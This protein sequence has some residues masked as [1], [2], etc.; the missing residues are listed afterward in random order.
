[1]YGAV[2]AHTQSQAVSAHRVGEAIELH[3]PRFDGSHGAP[4]AGLAKADGFLE[5]SEPGPVNGSA[6]GLG[7]GAADFGQRGDARAETF[8]QPSV[9]R[10]GGCFAGGALF[11]NSANPLR[12][13]DALPPDAAAEGAELQMAVRI[14]QPRHEEGV[15]QILDWPARRNLSAHAGD[16]T[17]FNQDGSVLDGG[18][19]NG[20]NH[21]ARRAS[22]V[23]LVL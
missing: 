21:P 4:G 19:G 1:M 3:Q 12:Q 22:F 2:R 6:V 9:D 8:L 14:D 11:N 7:L 23:I 10:L 15:A 5:Q 18:R 13:R 17:I 20:K 16:A